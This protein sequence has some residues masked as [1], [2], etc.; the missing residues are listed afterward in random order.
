LV[1]EVFSMAGMEPAGTRVLEIGCGTGQA[2]VPLERLACQVTA[3]E[4]GPRLAR[5]ARRKLTGFPRTSMIETKFENWESSG[6]FDLVFA[7]NSWHWFDPTVK[8]AK[9][10]SLLR[11]NG[12][13]AFI[14]TLHAFP[15]DADP[16][17]GE[18]QN[19]YEAIGEGR[20]KWP[21]PAPDEVP[22][23]RDEIESSGSFS[24]VRVARHLN[25]REFTADQYIDLMST[26]SDH[27]LM[28]PARRERLFAEM[29]RLIEARPGGRIRRHQLAI[30]HVARKVSG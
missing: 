24:D 13:L 8:Y 29:R 4:M 25:L 12:W 7:A 17:F 6:G 2:T 3:L 19:C 21:P 30:L 5:I 16:F 22:D 14:I 18:I 9:A 11:P 1:C 28:E 20:M 15:S 26:A 10:A 27:R 23:S